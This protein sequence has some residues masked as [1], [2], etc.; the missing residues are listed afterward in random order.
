MGGGL[1]SNALLDLTAVEGGKRHQF[2]RD[3]KTELAYV[4]ELLKRL[5]DRHVDYDE[6]L[7]KKSADDVQAAV[8]VSVD[9]PSV[10]EVMILFHQVK[11]RAQTAQDR[12]KTAEDQ[13]KVVNKVAL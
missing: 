9:T 3:R 4:Q 13:T 8:V 10:L 12:A 2:T 7:S 11:K 1:P 6:D 5:Q